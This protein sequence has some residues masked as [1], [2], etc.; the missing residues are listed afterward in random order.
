MKEEFGEQFRSIV[1]E[2]DMGLKERY[3]KHR[4]ETSIE[5]YFT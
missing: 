5:T 1:F 2:G 4:F 3:Q